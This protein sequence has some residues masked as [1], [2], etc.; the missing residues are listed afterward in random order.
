MIGG[1]CLGVLL[2]F[3]PSLYGEG[4]REINMSFRGDYSFLFHNTPFAGYQNQFMIVCMLFVSLIL[5][6]VFAVSLTFGA[7]GVGGIFA[8]SLFIG[9]LIGL[10]FSFLFS[11][12]NI[13]VPESVFD[14]F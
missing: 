1:L 10:F 12:F 7:G 8:P 11:S 4:F 13:R 9:A 3:F 14:G 6:K 2:F 5:I